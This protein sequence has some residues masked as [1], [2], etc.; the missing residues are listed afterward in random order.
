MTEAVKLAFETGDKIAKEQDCF[1]VDA[2]FVTEG[3]E[4]FLRLYIDKEGGVGIDEC[5][6]FSNAFGEIFDALDPISEEYILEVSSPGVD[7]TLKTKREFDYFAGREVSVKLYAALDGKKEFDGT[8]IKLEDDTVTVE[9]DG[10]E[11]SFKKKEAAFVRL[12]FKI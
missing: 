3:K 8:L 11:V 9:T 7:R 2:E 12:A 1:L 10:K 5:E 6:K 4:K